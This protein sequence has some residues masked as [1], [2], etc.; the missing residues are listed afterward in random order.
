MRILFI[1]MLFCSHTVFAND[2]FLIEG[3]I[4]SISVSENFVHVSVLSENRLNYDCGK[5][6][7]RFNLENSESNTVSALV[8]LAHSAMS[9]NQAVVLHGIRDNCNSA[10]KDFLALKVKVSSP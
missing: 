2:S 6:R 5:E 8:T 10:N 4:T 3:K 9:K 1:M 7:F